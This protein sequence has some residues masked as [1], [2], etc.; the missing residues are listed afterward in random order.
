VYEFLFSWLLVLITFVAWKMLKGVTFLEV[1]P[2]ESLAARFSTLW[3]KNDMLKQWQSNVAFHAYY[4]QLK[5]AI[6]EF[7]CLNLNTL[8][9]YR[10]L[11]N[12]HVERHF[13]YITVCKDESKEKL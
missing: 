13:I 12:F 5:H 7:P 4:Q 8:H 11:E 2:S 10:P 3:Y 6:E 9:Q 1:E